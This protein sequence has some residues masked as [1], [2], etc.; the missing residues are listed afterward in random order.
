MVFQR[1]LLRC[2]VSWSSRWSRFGSSGF[3]SL[4][5]LLTSLS[6]LFFDY[7][8]EIPLGRQE[9]GRVQVG[10]DQQL[11]TFGVSL[12]ICEKLPRKNNQKDLFSDLGK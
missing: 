1:N 6:L 12:R 8:F 2:P 4:T 11:L 9:R 5:K 7:P 10:G 3:S